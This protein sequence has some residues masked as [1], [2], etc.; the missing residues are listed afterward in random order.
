MNSKFIIFLVFL[1][2]ISIASVSAID[3]MNQTDIDSDFNK[4]DSECSSSVIQEESASNIGDEDQT[5]S[6]LNSSRLDSECCSFVIQEEN[7]TVFAFRQ[8]APLNGRGV[9][10]HNESLGDMEVIVQ[11]IDTPSNHFIHAIVTEDGWV[12]G[13]GGDSS[14]V[15]DTI[16]LENAAF[17]MLRSKDISSDCLTQIQEIF[18]RYGN[19]GHFLIKA[20]DGRYGVVYGETCLTGILTPGEFMVV[21][22][23]YAGFHKGN[24]T[25]YGLS[26]IEAVIEICSYEDTGFNRRNL[27]SYDYKAHDT[28]NGQKYGVDIYV[29]DDNGHNV[30]LDTSKIVTY[31]YFNDVRFSPSQI[32]QNPERLYIATHIFEKQSI[33]SKIEVVTRPNVVYFSDKE[34][35]QRN[36]P[37]RFRINNIV[38]ECTVVFDLDGES[39][40]FINAMTFQGNY[41]YDSTLH[42]VLWNLPAADCSKEIV[43]SFLPKSK[44]NHTIR[45]H[46]DGSDEEVEVTTYVSFKKLIIKAENVTTYKTYFKSMN[47]Y[48]TDEDG[49]PLIGEKVSITINGVTYSRTV[50]PKG[51][52]GFAIMLQPGEYDAVLYSE[53]DWY[54]AENT[55]KIIVKKTLFAEDLIVPYGKDCTFDAYGLDENGTALAKYSEIDF[56]IDGVSRARSTD[57]QGIASLNITRLNLDVGKYSVTIFN[58]RTN[59]YITNW[60]YIIDPNKKDKLQTEFVANT[61]TATYN[62]N[63]NLVITLKDAKGK[64]LSGVKITVVLN[65][66]KTYTT[67]KNGQIKINVA[68]LVPNTYTAK[69]TFAGNA[70]YKASEA[71]AKV[72]VKKANVKLTAKKKTFKAKV[73]VK[74]YTVI[75]KDNKGRVMKNVKLTLT[76][77]KRIYR[78][79][80]NSYGKA[81]FKIKLT[82]KGKYTA[83]TKFYSNKYYNA[84]TKK[85]QITIK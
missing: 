19:Y 56:L 76:I 61:V 38:D 42:K 14:N 45:A 12:I 31:C 50:T 52:A 67:D 46:I 30:G 74:K 32:P 36:F 70:N 39:A 73:K 28:A 27:Y 17:K 44:G 10:I 23:V 51:Y 34:D 35:E 58:V 84:V 78:A 55:S 62:I 9:Y 11:E 49:V 13:H 68:N 47:V 81:I 75:L 41:T 5:D 77:K 22:N 57:E 4:L 29:T 66:A 20:P 63:K 8:D 64:A 16:A 54:G 37:V 1:V 72:I 69:I 33:N 65:G 71:N 48:L 15:S 80:T 40:E 26:P 25:D 7:E 83:L 2:F 21:P 60:I 18:K 82:K 85:V 6:D 3:D 53:N 43:L 79:T 59:E 24:Y